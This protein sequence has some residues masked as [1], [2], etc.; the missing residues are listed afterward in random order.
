V[1]VDELL[2]SALCPADLGSCA[3]GISLPKN[4]ITANV[5]GPLFYE[6]QQLFVIIIFT[7]IYITH[8]SINTVYGK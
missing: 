7:I 8:G 3:S 4:T 2:A 1:V 6:K 5:Y